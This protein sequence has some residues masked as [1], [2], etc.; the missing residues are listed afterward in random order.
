MHL[1]IRAAVVAAFFVAGCQAPPASPE[2]GSGAHQGPAGP[3]A[4]ALR[5]GPRDAVLAALE[6]DGADLQDAGLTPTG[7]LAET[8]ANPETGTWT[9]LLT[10]PDGLTC[11]LAWGE[12]WRALTV[13]PRAEPE[14]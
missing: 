2:A 10:R 8:F 6:S 4:P 3:A 5:C 7:F 12:S 13:W 9:W 1:L 14:A 11:L